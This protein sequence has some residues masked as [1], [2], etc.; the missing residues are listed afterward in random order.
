[1]REEPMTDSIQYLTES[2]DNVVLLPDVV[3]GGLADLLAAA[4]APAQDHE[5]R[6]ELAARTAFRS[7]VDSWPAKK[8]FRG[9]RT[10]AVV[11]A[12]SMA[13]LLLAT[14]GLSAATG[15]PGPAARAVD[16]ILGSVGVHVAPPAPPASPSAS[17]AGSSAVS[18]PALHSAGSAH[19]GCTTGGGGANATSGEV[20]TAS[21]VVNAPAASPGRTGRSTSASSSTKGAKS[22]AASTSGTRAGATVL[23]KTPHPHS[24]TTGP[25]SGGNHRTT[26]PPTV[27][28]PGGGT[29]R[30]GNQGVGGGRGC[31][32]GSGGSTTTTTT[33]TP[34]TT[35]STTST[36][37]PSSTTTGS[38]GHGAGHHHGGSGSGSGSGGSDP[39]GSGGTGAA[40]S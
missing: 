27:T 13:G 7:A 20:Q 24:H 16:G 32:G 33:T 31:K 6:G 26:T 25:T 37:D 12:T 35:T 5:L 29:S 36:T 28:P 3:E 14:T 10:P 18:A 4:G 21:C 8:R 23:A 19:V 34:T 9:R 39:G 1:M 30:G 2:F 15:L 22:S 17:A 11:A 38:C 40:T